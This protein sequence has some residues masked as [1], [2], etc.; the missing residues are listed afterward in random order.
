FLANMSHEIRTPLNGIM[1]M[2]QILHDSDLE[3]QHVHFVEMA[4]ESSKRLTRLLSDILDLSRV[5]AGKMQIQIEPFDLKKLLQDF[6]ALHEPVSIQTGVRIRLV[7]HE[8]LPKMVCGDS[9]RI[10]QILTNLVGNAFK[11]TRSGSIVLDASPLPPR[12]PGK[13]W[14]LFTVADTGCGMADGQLAKLFEPFVQAS[15]G[16]TRPHQGAGLGL[17]IVK[18]IVELMGGSIAVESELG[19]GTAFYVSIPFLAAPATEETDKEKQKHASPG[20]RTKRVLLAED[21]TVS[22]IAASWLLR[23]EGYA[24]DTAK[25][26]QEAIAVLREKEIDLILMDVQMPVMDGVEAAR[27]IRCGEAGADKADIPII[28]LTAYAMEGDRKKLLAAG[29]NEYVAKPVERDALREA[30]E[31]VLSA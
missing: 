15:Q 17:S 8:A 9:I 24:I 31:R 16:F 14:V 3:K 12:H 26:G 25:N 18:R 11:F 2:L 23:K 4:I 20:R 7:M 30:I 27:R 22:A 29:M 28:A 13:T 1:G 21:E 10:Q 6:I 19:T 5:E